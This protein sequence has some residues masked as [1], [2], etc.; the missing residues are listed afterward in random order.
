MGCGEDLIKIVFEE[1]PSIYEV[2]KKDLSKLN[3][4]S[5]KGEGIAA[6]SRRLEEGFKILDNIQRLLGG[7]IIIIIIIEPSF[8]KM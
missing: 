6:I 3:R 2:T 7:W 5:S 8:I 4:F 1:L